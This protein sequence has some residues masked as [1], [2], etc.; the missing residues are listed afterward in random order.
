MHKD[1]ILANKV[2][3]CT[4][5]F[6]RSLGLR[7]SRLRKDNAL[8]FVNPREGILESIVD[9]FFVFSEVDILWL[10]SDKKVVDR[11]TAKPFTFLK[12][13]KAAKYVIELPKDAAKRVMEGDK[14]EIK[15]CL[16][17]G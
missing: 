12:P 9:M 13:K 2:K 7:F 16:G 8:V 5:I 14:I 6:S 1:R 3:F 11:K 15:G 17:K 4:N 10:D